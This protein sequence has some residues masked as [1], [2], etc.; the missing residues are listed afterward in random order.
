MQQFARASILIFLSIFC[1]QGFAQQ[2]NSLL[3]PKLSV[4]TDLSVPAGAISLQLRRNFDNSRNQ[5]GVVGTRWRCNWESRL[6]RDG[7]FV[8]IEDWSGNVSFTQTGAQSEYS[9]PSGERITFDKA[10]QALRTTVD[11]GTEVFDAGGRLIQRVYH[12][13]NKIAIRYD[14]QG[15]ISRVEGPGASF[16]QFRMDDDGRVVQIDASTGATVRYK[17]E[18]ND[19]IEAQ[20]NGG[21]PTR[22]GYDAKGSLARIDQPQIGSIEITYDSQGRV[23]SYR[24]AD[25]SNQRFE[26][27]E[28]NNTRRVI[29]ANGAATVTEQSP[30]KRRT[31]ITDPLGNKSTIQF[32]ET[33]RPVTITG[34]TG[35][36]AKMRYDASGRIAAA[37]D[38]LGNATRYEYAGAGSAMKTVIY[39]DGSRQEFEYDA[40]NNLIATRIGGKTVTSLTYNPDGSIA[41]ARTAGAKEQKFTY[42]PN[43]LVRSVAN[44]LGETTQFQYDGRGNLVREI[45]PLGGVTVRGYDSQ[46]R[47]VSITNPAGG[48]TGY[49]Y[50]Y[51]GRLIRQTDA[52][53]G[54]TRFDYDA[55]GRLAAE[56]NPAGETTR[57]EYSSTDKLIRTVWSDNTTETYRYDLAGNLVE[58]TDRLGRLFSF[59]RDPLGRVIR[60]QLPSGLERRYRY[61][62]AGNVLAVDDS[63]GAHIEYQTDAL[64]RNTTTISS[65]AKTQYQYDAL[66]ALLSVTDPLGRAKQF[67][68]NPEGDLIGVAEPSHDEAR[69]EYDP[70]GRIVAIHRPSGGVTRYT[71]NAMGQMLTAT[72]PLGRMKRYTYDNAGRV[73]SSTDAGART[74]RYVYDASGNRVEEQLPDGKRVAYKY[75]GLG[76]MIEADDGAFPVRMSYDERGNLKRLEYVAINKTVA[77]EYD[78]FGLRTKMI[79]PDARETRYEYDALKR[80]SAILPPDA[81]RITFAYDVKN[82]IQ[83]VAYPNGI[84]GQW[85]YDASG[86]IV[87]V[88]YKDRSGKAVAGSSYRYDLAGNPVERQDSQGE[89]ARY[90]YDSANQLIEEAS[91]EALIKYAYAA[92]G[93]RATVTDGAAVRQFKSDAADQLIE[94]GAE[95]LSYD[96]NGNLT[97]RKGPGGTIAYEYDIDNRLVKVVSADGASTTFGYAPTG[98]RVWRRDREGVTYFLY[99][100]INLIAELDAGLRAKATY[101]Y[102]PGIDRPL[103]ML[104]EKRSYYYLA[105]RLGSITHVTDDQGKVVA[106]N[107]YD[108]FGKI[109]AK[110]GTLANPFAYAGREFDSTGLYY[111]RAR[112]YDPELGRFLSKDQVSPRPDEPLEQN[113]YLFVRNSPVR[114]VDPLGFDFYTPEDLAGLS[115]TELLY[116]NQNAR[117]L[118]PNERSGEIVKLTYMAL[119][120]K[121]GGKPEADFDYYGQSKRLPDG[122]IQRFWKPGSPPDLEGAPLP[123]SVPSPQAVGTPGQ[124]A[125]NLNPTGEV[126]GGS[127]NRAGAN[128]GEVRPQPGPAGGDTLTGGDTPATGN[129][130]SGPAPSQGALQRVLSGK[131]LLNVDPN[132]FWKV[133]SG[134]SLAGTLASLTSVAVDCY[135]NPANCSAS[136]L[137]AGLAFAGAAKALLGAASG[138]VLTLVQGAFAWKKVGSELLQGKIDAAQRKAEEDAR[139]AQELANLKNRDAYYTRIEQLRGKISG[140]EKDH[141]TVIKN[142]PKAE[143]QANLAAN[144]STAAEKSIT[145]LRAAKDKK[146]FVDDQI[147]QLVKKNNHVV[148]KNSIDAWTA[149]AEDKQRESDRLLNEARQ[150]A[151]NCASAADAQAI[152]ERY[153]R[154]KPLL[155][156]IDLLKKQADQKNADLESLRRQIENLKG[157]SPAKVSID[158]ADKELIASNAAKEAADLITPVRDSIKALEAGKKQFNGEI[159]ALQS[160]IP[161]ALV[162]DIQDRVNDL[163][164]LLSSLT[165]YPPLVRYDEKALESA[166][167]A[168][169]Y[170]D[171]AVRILESWKQAPCQTEIPA[172]DTN[173]L[174]TARSMTGLNVA[175]A[176]DLLRQAQVCEA[177]AK[178]IPLIN[179]ARQLLERLEIE[180]G[181]AAINQARQQG[182]NV[183]GLNTTLDYY[184]SIRD[185]AALLFN[186]KEQCK[187]QDGLAFAEKMPA[188][189]QNNA[190][191]AN[192]VND[193]RAGLAAQQQVE[194]AIT[195]AT[196]AAVEGSDISRHAPTQ[197]AQIDKLFG[198]ADSFLAQADRLAAAYPCLVERVSKYKT[199]YNKLKLSAGVSLSAQPTDDVPGALDPGKPTD[200]VPAALDPGKPTDQVPGA[201]DPNTGQPPVSN[202]PGDQTGKQEKKPGDP[203]KPGKAAT[204]GKILGAIVQGVNQANSSRGSGGGKTGGGGNTGGSG[205]GNTGGSNGTGGNTGGGGP[206][207][208]GTLQGCDLTGTWE[209]FYQYPKG[210]GVYAQ[211]LYYRKQMVLRPSGNNTWQGTITLET[212]LPPQGETASSYEQVKSLTGPVTV[213]FINAE[214]IRMAIQT[215]QGART[216]QGNCRPPGQWGNQGR[217]AEIETPNISFTKK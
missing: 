172:V 148:V 59:E 128:T 143:Q 134:V 210:G 73:L 40:N 175:A 65:G 76:R 47:I 173:A 46:D 62:S 141:D 69:Y 147:C 165:T 177:S 121:F 190:W 185:A 170:K 126:N 161:E 124:A 108:A 166:K 33:G 135:R 79:A 12:H 24:R 14:A 70:A 192:G 160:A 116:L 216:E 35:A 105:D 37:E 63:S 123:G 5:R 169:L 158:A 39:P 104:Q 36:S 31:E 149:Q 49:E 111:Y 182:C 41:T 178:C 145:D 68:H 101:V 194:E 188:S 144:A 109:K 3:D 162:R 214:G 18:R 90:A 86:Q 85:D 50:D 1:I 16:L 55:L 215:S 114:F 142:L 125:R 167:R 80:L 15:W 17:Y 130:I 211:G 184:R 43:G 51:R 155:A 187:F 204:I 96:A 8:R 84:T 180:S 28:S 100:G 2:Q 171:E 140:L 133:G 97:N 156:Q 197:R 164:G 94:A 168:A 60:E 212:N 112:Y 32:D 93:N 131:G 20:V 78:A 64:K 29:E 129:T 9:S 198:Q 120:P 115:D 52:G 88:S 201:L 203:N 150:F 92:G 6:S 191:I 57:Y 139:K 152:R 179:Q 98:E 181:E 102:G 27:D 159:N 132:G 127:P 122:S 23:S 74:R 118:F 26:Y 4:V 186:A 146:E 195:N 81:K 174:E 7:Q 53:G 189:I 107:S 209:Y 157:Q 25:G 110:Q 202:N 113:P 208:G 207:T 138:P 106:S 54:A 205:G 193:L 183:D 10:G 89:T 66:G 136:N 11:G 117:S 196:N 21:L 103:A 77:Y 82:R 151:A 45:N 13:G 91:A 71:Y 176:G 99:D 206:V 42:Y 30:E 95:R 44:A 137:A 61:D 58:R 83:S 19:L 72:D 67:A 48:T 199:E 213:T 75:D 154:I 200:D 38:P 22:Y 34:P 56:T 217:F 153:A 163:R 119:R 87:S